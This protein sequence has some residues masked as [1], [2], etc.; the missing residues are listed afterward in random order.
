M[1]KLKKIIMV[2]TVLL[3]LIGIN[4]YAEQNINSDQQIKIEEQQETFGINDFL[5]DAKEYTGEFFNDIDISKI[6]ENAIQGKVDNTNIYK[7]ILNLLGE[8]VKTT[9]TSLVS[10]LTIILIHSVLKAISEN[11]EN[12][13]ISKIIYYVQYILIVT[14]IMTNVSDVV[15]IVKEATTNL[16]G[17]MN[18]LVPLLINLMLFTG[19]ITTS[20]VLEPIILFSINFLGNIIQTVIIPI[21][22]VVTSI[23]VISKISDQIKINKISDF[24]KSGVIGFLGIILTIFVGII[25]LEGTLSSSVDGIAAKTTKTIV[26]SAIPVVG[27]I[28]GDAVDTVL[29]CGLVLKNAVGIV[30][31]IIVVGICIIPII[32]LLVIMLSY[33]LLSAVSQ[34]IAEEKIINLLEQMGD[35]FK[36]FLAILCS[37]SVMIIIGTTLVIKMSNSGMMYR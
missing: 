29:G 19:S 32:K 18:M 17:F 9:V 25:S 30:G 4:T 7:K 33:K 16:I 24:L 8:E 26:S 15:S 23:C 3:M 37:I 11:I 22:L 5:K 10:I 20:S 36:I 34:P 12:S 6:L 13:N 27:K 35:I 14:I 2:C 21:V 31:V 28:L 1:K